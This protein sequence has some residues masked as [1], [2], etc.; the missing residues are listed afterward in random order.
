MPPSE[1]NLNKLSDA[2]QAMSQ[3]VTQK[4][5]NESETSD[6]GKKHLLKKGLMEPFSKLGYDINA[7]LQEYTR[8]FKDGDFNQT[9]GAVIMGILM[10]YK[11]QAEDL[12]KH[13]LLTAEVA[14]GLQTLNEK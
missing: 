9:E 7:T 2:V 6:A 5:I 14:R 3:K 4:E 1:K 11:E 12:A 13:G 8:R 10:I